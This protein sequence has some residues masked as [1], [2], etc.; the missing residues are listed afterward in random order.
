MS[1]VHDVLILGGGL[2]GS[3]LA[4][5]LRR[6]IPECDVAVVERATET[7]HKVGESLVE[8]GSNYL[9]RRLGLS[10]HLYE[11]HLPKNGLRFF[12]DG[13][14]RDMDLERLGEIGSDALP[15]HPSF[16][17]DRSRIE[18]T[19]LQENAASGIAVLRGTKVLSIE[20]GQRGTPH[21]ITVVDDAGQRTMR[22][23]WLVDASGRARLL[24]RT[25]GTPRTEVDHRLAAAWGRMRGVADIDA[26][27]SE[28]WRARVRHTSRYLSTNH[29]C[30]RGYWLWL[31]PLRGGLT[32]VG[33]VGTQDRFS[34]AY[35]EPT[36][37]MNALR[38]HTG[39]QGLLADAEL[40]DLLSYGNLSYGTSWFLE[41]ARRLALTGE[42]AAFSDPFYSPGSDFIA[43][44]NDLIT[45]LV[46]RDLADREGDDWQHRG[47]DYD[48][49][50]QF[51]FEATMLLYRELY[52]LLGSRELMQ[53]R[54]N[55]DIAAYYNLWLHAYLRDEHLDLGWVRDQLER[56]EFVLAAL[57]NFNR[58][59]A[60]LRDTVI[61][62]GRYHRGNLDVFVDGLYKVDFTSAVGTARPRKTVLR[63]T[64]NIFNEV[65]RD[66]LALA[67][68]PDARLRADRPLWDFMLEPPPFIPCASPPGAG[69]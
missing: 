16:Q 15:F 44:E 26:V 10:R 28:A 19:L 21:E 45:D 35:R 52:E 67:G 13:P 2:A 61:A 8:I 27:G 18:E 59:F 1:R 34:S 58:L 17:I 60:G 6:T 39:M 4:R 57:R 33:W 46:E 23:R 51:R 65:L 3:T 40:V 5:Q 32:S 47:R 56:K 36:G 24:Q 20:P 68:E 29:F 9:V 12:F 42:A 54:W 50:L 48:A 38:E 55:F 37:F 22:G 41:P 14:Q 31:I 43:L 63:T 7:T 66:A 11:Q 69:T 64:A 25:L 53:L 49:F 62:Q 30:Y